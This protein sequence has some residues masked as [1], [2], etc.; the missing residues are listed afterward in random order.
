M[1]NSM[2]FTDRNTLRES[3]LE[4]LRI[5]S[6]FFIVLGHAVVHGK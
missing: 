6:M 1:L 2:I 3:K 4:I 5:F